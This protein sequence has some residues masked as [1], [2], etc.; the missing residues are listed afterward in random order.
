MSWET[1]K[2]PARQARLTAAK[3]AEEKLS[4][5]MENHQTYE[6]NSLHVD[7]LEVEAKEL[8]SAIKI[9]QKLWRAKRD[10]FGNAKSA[11]HITAISMALETKKIRLAMAT[12]DEAWA[13]IPDSLR[14]S[15]VM[16]EAKVMLNGN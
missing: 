6:L 12:N 1:M 13:G 10:A 15:K 7:A 14:E 16:Q 4:L 5:A 3:L 2:R 8:D 11:L 9:L